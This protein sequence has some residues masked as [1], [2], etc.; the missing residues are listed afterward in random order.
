MTHIFYVLLRLTKKSAV[1]WQT[2]ICTNF[3]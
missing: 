3:V 1:R 2:N